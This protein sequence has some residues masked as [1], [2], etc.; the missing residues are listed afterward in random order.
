M[1]TINTN[2]TGLPLGEL[3]LKE[4]GKILRMINTKANGDRR[5]G[6][7]GAIRL[8]ATPRILRRCEPAHA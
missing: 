8:S 6:R 4:E 7:G 5:Q 3:S 2:H 1:S